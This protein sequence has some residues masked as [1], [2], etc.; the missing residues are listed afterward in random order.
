MSEALNLPLCFMLERPTF[1]QYTDNLFLFKCSLLLISMGAESCTACIFW[2]FPTMHCP[3]PLLLQ[4]LHLP[5]L[6]ASVWG[7]FFPSRFQTPAIKLC[8]D[9]EPE[10]ALVRLALPQHSF[11]QRN[12]GCSIYLGNTK[13]FSIQIWHRYSIRRRIIPASSHLTNFICWTAHAASTI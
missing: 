12:T 5:M 7:Y 4:L 8:C 3:Q 6:A 2:H 10:V 9:Q 11:P 13:C 1:Y